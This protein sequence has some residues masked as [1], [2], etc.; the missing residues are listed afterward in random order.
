MP[1]YSNVAVRRSEASAGPFKWDEIDEEAE[2][3]LITRGP[4]EL[5]NGSIYRGQWSRGGL[6]HGRGI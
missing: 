1:D 3:D 4:Y 2:K 6:R 5:D